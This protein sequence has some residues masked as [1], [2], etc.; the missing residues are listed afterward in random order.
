MVHRVH[1][2]HSKVTASREQLRTS[3]D[4]GDAAGHNLSERDS[5]EGLYQMHG[6]GITSPLLTEPRQWEHVCFPTISSQ[7]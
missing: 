4:D 3:K 1:G 5:N 2:V 6:Q 7:W